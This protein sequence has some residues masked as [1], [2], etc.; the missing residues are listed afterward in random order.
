MLGSG[1]AGDCQSL[2]QARPAPSYSRRGSAGVR[3]VAALGAG[4][5]LLAGGAGFLAREFVGMAALVGGA[6][7]QAGD[8]ALALGVHGSKAAQ[9]FLGGGLEIVGVVGAGLGVHGVL[10][11]V[12]S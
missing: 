1:R 4:M 8:F 6:S 12:E 10:V 2:A 3:G 11:W 9:G 5:A 7:A